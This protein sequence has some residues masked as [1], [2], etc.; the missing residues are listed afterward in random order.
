V[1]VLN[2]NHNIYKIFND[3]GE[4]VRKVVE[5]EKIVDRFI[6][7]QPPLVLKIDREI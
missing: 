3:D 5:I 4:E 1:K 6:Y 2:E 7:V